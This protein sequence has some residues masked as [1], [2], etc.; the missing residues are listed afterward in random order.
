MAIATLSSSGLALLASV[1]CILYLCHRSLRFVPIAGIPYNKGSAYT[2]LGDIPRLLVQLCTG[3]A[4][5][6]WL[7]DETRRQ[8]SPVVQVFVRIFRQP[9]VIVADHRESQDILLRRTKEFD[10]SAIQRDLFGSIVPNFHLHFS[11]DH[12]DFKKHKNIVRNLMTPAFLNQV[13]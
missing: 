4:L 3:E 7:M 5:F 11:S 1:G 12:E 2:I 9:W 13:S 6:P 8:D 10:R